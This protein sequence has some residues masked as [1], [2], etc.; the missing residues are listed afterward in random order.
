MTE[1]LGSGLQNRVQ[2]FES[3]WYL[4][5]IILLQSVLAYQYAKT[6][7]A[8]S[9]CVTLYALPRAISAKMRIFA[10]SFLSIH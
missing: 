10:P 5:S 9:F 4:H 8:F 1:W 6:L 2:Q 7:L 3:A